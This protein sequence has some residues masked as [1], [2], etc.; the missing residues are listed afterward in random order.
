[1]SDIEAVVGPRVRTFGRLE[2]ELSAELG[3]RVLDDWAIIFKLNSLAPELWDV[4]NLPGRPEPYLTA[5]LAD[6]L[7]DGFDRLRLASVGWDRL[8]T[9]EPK[10][11]AVTMARLGRLYEEWLGM[12]DDLFSRRL[13]LLKALSGSHLWPF[14][15][16]DKVDIIYCGHSQRLS[17]FEAEL[18][19]ALAVHHDVELRMEAPPWLLAE[20]VTRSGDYH[21]LRLAKDLEANAPERFTLTWADP[22]NYLHPEVPAALRFASEN[23]FGPPPEQIPP[24]PT[25]VLRIVEAP[26]RYHEAEEVCRRLKSL[27]VGGIPPHRLGV[28]VPTV[29][30]YLP[31][32]EDVARRFGLVFDHVK[33]AKLSEQAPVLAVLDLLALWDS[34]WELTRILKVLESSFFEFG[35]EGPVRLAFLQAGILDDRASGGIKDNFEKVFDPKLKEV[36]KAAA[37]AVEM[38]R[39]AKAVLV[40]SEDWKQ[41]RDRLQSILT[42]FGWP[43]PG[44][45]PAIPKNEVTDRFLARTKSE[46]LAVGSFT[47][48]LDCLFNALTESPQAPPVSLDSFRLWL[49]RALSG[50]EIE[51]RRSTGGGIKLSNYYDLHGAFFETLFLMGLNDRVFPGGQAESCWWPKN[52]INALATGFLGRRLWSDAAESYQREEEMVVGALSQAKQVVLTYLASDEQNRPALPSPLIESLKG[53]WPNGELRPE[54]PGWPLPPPAE[55][56]CDQ[57]ELWL[58]LAVNNQADGAPPA[59]FLELSGLGPAAESLWH[60]I[61]VRRSR[62]ALY[63]TSLT[64]RQLAAY[65]AS[66]PRDKG[67]PV[68]GV[69]FLTGYRNCPRQFWLAQILG[70]ERWPE[71]SDMWPPTTWGE[72]IHQSLE[73]F[74]RP[75]L[76]ANSTKLSWD[77]LKYHFWELAFRLSCY[78]PIGRRPVWDADAKR[79]EKILKDWYERQ[80]NQNHSKLEALEWSFGPSD[81]NSGSRRQPDAPAFEIETVKGAFLLKGRIDRIDWK[82]G[83]IEIIDYKTR[84]SSY[85]LDK[86]PSD[87][88]EREAYEYPM[89]LYSLA[90]AKFFRSEVT[91]RLEF[92]DPNDK[93]PTLDIPSGTEDIFAAMWEAVL[94]GELPPT[95]DETV[96]SWC[97]F[98][99]LCGEYCNG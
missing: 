25:G 29:A 46:G 40:Q 7:G 90:A 17:P 98:T 77:L 21:R 34:N 80:D 75:L 92:I 3:P 65:L 28:A 22:D 97:D 8:E 16:L 61:F 99:R 32:L 96:C 60:S 20:N 6:Q 45:D 58:N 94:S 5:E 49:G 35:L 48:A 82:D 44:L 64:D 91:A 76:N 74:Y 24:D 78:N 79:Y 87:G 85:Y 4:L 68:V 9:L 33:G 36:L 81:L 83:K 88:A 41:F 43:G 38:L 11:L 23:L 54:K 53:L 67:K 71:P 2:S 1:M 73:R 56:V 39:A 93:E 84:R 37:D 59:E 95:E 62:L 19:K 86:P 52:F 66:L 89:I 51:D 10:E 26:T 69:S 18:L 63:Q 50:A 30:V 55:R 15:V 13:K 72:V 70:L 57:G 47:S 14:K 27:I 31:A 12:R 42:G